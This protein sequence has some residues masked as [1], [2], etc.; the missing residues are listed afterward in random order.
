MQKITVV[1]KDSAAKNA[2]VIALRSNFK[3]IDL[4]PEQTD[5]NN[6]NSAGLILHVNEEPNQE[7]SK[8]PNSRSVTL[9]LQTSKAELSDI[10]QRVFLQLANG[11]S[12]KDN[13][14]SLYLSRSEYFKILRQ[15]RILFDMGKNWELTQLARAISFNQ[16]S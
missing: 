13:W 11:L 5:I 6:I 1:G 15:L 2:V 9:E 8:R 14:E 7:K 16:A 3:V 10:Q 12:D 4:H